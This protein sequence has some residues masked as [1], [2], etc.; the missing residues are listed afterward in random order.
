LQ[1]L[2]FWGRRLFAD[3]TALVFGEGS[4]PTSVLDGFPTLRV[5]RL[6]EEAARELLTANLDA[7][8]DRELVDRIVRD[9]EGNPLALLEVVRDLALEDLLGTAAAPQPIPL[10]RRLEQRFERH[11]RSLPDDSQMLLLLAAADSTADAHLVWNAAAQLGITAEAAAPAALA[12]LVVL[13]PPIAFRH[14]LIRSAVYSS[15]PPAQRLA[16]H[17]ALATAIGPDVDPQRYAWHLAAA[18]S[19]RDERV[20][21]VIE[22]V[23]KQADAQGSHAAAHALLARAAELTPDRERAAERRVS[24]AEAAVESNAPRQARALVAVA[25]SELRDERTMARARRIDGYALQ[26]MSRD[27]D[28]TPCLLS[29]AVDLMPTDPDLARET[30]VDALAAAL[31]AGSAADP[32][33]QAVAAAGRAAITGDGTAVD[34]TL[35]AFSTYIHEGFVAA[36]PLLRDVVVNVLDSEV[37]VVHLSHAVLYTNASEALWD[38]D[39]HDALAAVLVRASE[40][41]GDLTSLAIALWAQANSEL[42]SGQFSVAD[43]Y[44]ARAADIFFAAGENPLADVLARLQLQASIGEEAETRAKAASIIEIAEHIGVERAST[45]AHLALVTLDIGAT[46]YQEALQHAR[47]VYDRDPMNQGNHILPDMIEAAVRAGDGAA[48]DKAIA[49]LHARARAAG[50][51]WALGLLARSQGVIG[52]EHAQGR[53][54]EAIEL[55]GSTRVHLETARAHLLFGEWLRRQRRPT[56]A[57]EHLHGAYEMFS[58]FGAPA[59]AERCRRE[60]LASGERPATRGAPRIT[61]L[62]PQEANVARL[63]ATGCTNVEIGAQL[64]IAPT[65]VDYHLRR[66]FRKLSITSRRQLAGALSDQAPDVRPHV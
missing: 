65:T 32:D 61:Q 15:V 10:A 22:G 18:T 34:V 66:V 48:A 42:W 43:L 12:E 35:R 60:L 2:A 63:A 37:P 9:S 30:L 13:G 58:S 14:P 54:E 49:R 7:G 6:S 36:Q 55:L 64:Y 8:L 53:F 39:L 40:N 5:E 46:R 51:P 38:Q 19:G 3:A 52:V 27:K 29:A 45:M 44:Y 47:I 33:A 21:S 28:A 50:T 1:A 59:F 56:E 41:E 62:T 4:T 11:V 26:R 20:A 16:A 23:G 57:R 25:L 31:T 17:R 24:A